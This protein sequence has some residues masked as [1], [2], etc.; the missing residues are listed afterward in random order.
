MCLTR[1]HKERPKESMLTSRSCASCKFG[2]LHGSIIRDRI[3][4]GIRSNEVGLGRDSRWNRRVFLALRHKRKETD[5]YSP[6]TT[7]LY[8]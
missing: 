2:E 7:S 1:G 8:S 3:V 5:N 6:N 4:C